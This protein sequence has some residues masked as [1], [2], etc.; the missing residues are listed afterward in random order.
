MSIIKLDDV[1]IKYRG[2]P[3]YALR[4]LNLKVER[5][6]FLGIIG[7]TGAGKSTLC[8][9]L[10]GLIPHLVRPDEFTGNVVVKGL[11]TKE[12]KIAELSQHIGIVFQDYESQLFCTNT[13]LEVAFGLENL[14]IPRDEMKNRIEQALKWTRLTGLEKH[15]TFNLS[16]GQKQRLAIAAVLAMHPSIIVLDEATSDL[17]PVGK[18]EVYEIIK[19][20]RKREEVTMIM[21]DHHLDRVAEVADRVVVVNKGKIIYDDRP[22]EVFSHVEELIELGLSPPQVAEL[23]HKIGYEGGYPLSVTEAMEK[24]PANYGIVSPKS[25]LKPIGEPVIEIR[26]L[27]HTYDGERWVLKNINVKVHRG[28]FVALIGQNGS[29]KTTLALCING[30]VKPTK[31]SIR[32][33]GEEA[34]LKTVLELGKTVGYVY[35]N[36]DYM[37][38]SDT[39]RAELE[40]GPKYAELPMEEVDRRVDH[41]LKVLEIEDLEKEDPFFLNKANRQRV[42]VGS[43]LTV[44]PEILIVDEPTTGLAPGETRHIMKLAQELNSMGKTIIVISH[45][46][47]VI[48]E[49]CKRILVLHNGDLIMDGPTREVFSRTNILRKTFIEPPQISRFSQAK[50]GETFLSVDEMV[51]HVSKA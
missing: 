43:V 1:W 18:Y 44:E 33:L 11:N 41:A 39:V 22:R 8:I 32:I 50:F 28:E 27:S 12:H 17:D 45:D 29:G 10:N 7:P 21:V 34:T 16:G 2:Q 51:E 23:F 14:A 25:E 26:N 35:Q 30:V 6:E 40:M 19:D 31:G 4:D 3:D 36:P 20:L 24:F 49:Y 46:M 48:S 42:A 5:G 37:I 13:E 9:T 15:Y 47:W 38:Y